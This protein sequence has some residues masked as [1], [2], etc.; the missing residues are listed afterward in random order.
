MDS[1]DAGDDHW[2]L[3]INDVHPPVERHQTLLTFSAHVHKLS[4]ESINHTNTWQITHQYDAALELLVSQHA[5][6]VALLFQL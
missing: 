1:D 6:D 2:K 5:P 3:F 4:A